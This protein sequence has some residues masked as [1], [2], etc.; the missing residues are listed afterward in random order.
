MIHFESGLHFDVSSVG[1]SG[2]VCYVLIPEGVTAELSGWAEE[3]SGR[4]GC[5]VVLVSG[6][7]WNN[8]MTPWPAPGVMKKK[9]EFGGAA[10]I[11]IDM[12]LDEHIPA[13]E[14]RFGLKPVKRCLAGISLSGLFAVWSLSRTDA[15]DF[16][17]S[18]SGS[19]WYDGFEEWV[20]TVPVA[21]R[22]KVYISLGVKEKE[23]KDRRMARVE[24]C[25]RSVVPELEA[26]GLEVRF[27]MVPGTHFSPLAPKLDKALEYFFLRIRRATP[28]DVPFIAKCVLAAVDLYDFKN[29][30]IEREVMEQVCSKDDT[31]FSYRN[32]KIAEVYGTPVCCMVAYDGAIYP[33][34][35]K[36]T[37]KYF[38]EI[39]RSMNGSAIETGPGEYYFDSIAIVPEYRGHGI[40]HLMM[41]DGLNDAREGGFK[42]VSLL[43]ECSKP[44]LRDYYAE[45]GFRP[46][47]EMFA[48]GDMYLKMVLDLTEPAPC[49]GS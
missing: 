21:S 35:R 46:E 37:F 20:K 38:D 14:E 26:K 36:R 33:E 22:A 23:A 32:S 13:F 44:K 15:F 9:K 27:E 39:G 4:F 8:D 5:T 43:V 40:A 28:D 25:T 30:S 12:L 34:G 17:A 16:V 19:L 2:A 7:D 24:D 18:V 11:F 31:L 48:F 41:E 49:A 10:G 47:S 45:L 1:K 42:K 3:A 29:D 6:M